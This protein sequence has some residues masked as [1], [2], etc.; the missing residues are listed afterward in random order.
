MER[1]H[2]LR[3]D[4]LLKFNQMLELRDDDPTDWRFYISKSSLEILTSEGDIHISLEK[5]L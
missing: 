2:G 3:K 4:D 1:R 5:Q